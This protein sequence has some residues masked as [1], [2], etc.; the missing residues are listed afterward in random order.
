MLVCVCVYL[1]KCVCVCVCACAYVYENVV[2]K[3][4]QCIS[5]TLTSPHCY[6]L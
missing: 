4:V 6:G 1:C 2:K 3:V 5:E